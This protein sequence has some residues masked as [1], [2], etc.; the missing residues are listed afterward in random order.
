MV[1]YLAKLHTDNNVEYKLPLI[2]LWWN[3]LVWRFR[4]EL[5]EEYRRLLNLMGRPNGNSVALEDLSM[6]GLMFDPDGYTV[7]SLPDTFN[8]H[9]PQG[10]FQKRMMPRIARFDLRARMKGGICRDGRRDSQ[11]HQDPRPGWGQR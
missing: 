7:F 9:D 4:V 8:P 6:A 1:D 3:E 2:I 5:E 11:L 10:W